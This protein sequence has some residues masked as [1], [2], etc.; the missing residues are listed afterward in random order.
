MSFGPRAS[1]FPVAETSN[2]AAINGENSIVSDDINITEFVNASD[3]LPLSPPVSF[4]K[5]L[6]MQDK[7]VVVTIRYS[8]GSGLKPYYLTVAKRIKMSHPDVLIEKRILPALDP[9]TKEEP[10]FEVLVDGKVCVGK[11]KIQIQKLGS[12]SNV[13]DMTG[14]M[15]VF[16]SM[17]E[18]DTIISKARRRRRPN[19]LYGDDPARID[20]EMLRK[21]QQTEKWND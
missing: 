4:E 2:L 6:T 14:G 11:G 12:K 18:L 7:R 15:S 16:V 13:E 19:T 3:L 21:Q 1:S 8:G 10:T 17:Q 9:D 20:L 5:F